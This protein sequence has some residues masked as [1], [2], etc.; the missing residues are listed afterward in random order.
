MSFASSTAI[1][2]S[3]GT[4]VDTV[5]VE[6]LGVHACTE[7]LAT[8][9]LVE[10]REWRAI[11]FHINVSL[12]QRPFVE[13]RVRYCARQQCWTFPPFTEDAGHAAV[14]K[15]VCRGSFVHREENVRYFL[16]EVA[17]N[18][19]ITPAAAAA[20]ST[21]AA[22]EKGEGNRGEENCWVLV[23]EVLHHS[24]VY[25]RRLHPDLRTLFRTFP[26]LC[27]LC[28]VIS[29]GANHHDDAYHPQQRQQQQ[30]QQSQTQPHHFHCERPI[31]RYCWKSSEEELRFAFLFGERST[32]DDCA[33]FVPFFQREKTA[34]G[35]GCLRCAVF[36]GTTRY[37]PEARR[38]ETVTWMRGSGAWYLHFDSVLFCDGAIAIHDVLSR[39]VVLDFQWFTDF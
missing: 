19:F 16:C 18:V 4:A 34:L 11:E 31:V 17:D 20:P 12:P 7:T 1:T 13:F 39:H 26:Q 22:T 37:S 2:T 10:D 3:T 35:Q 24:T 30:Q 33:T 36:P 5:V 25:A 27:E 29:A 38:E 28:P 6:Y 14:A 15:P 32:G 9:P 23:D 8:I 21:A